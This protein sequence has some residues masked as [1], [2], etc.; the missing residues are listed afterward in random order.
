[1]KFGV[2]EDINDPLK[3]GRVR[4]RI[5]GIHTDDTSLVPIS[6]LPWAMCLCPIQ[7][8]SVS[9]I[10]ISPTGIVQGAWV[11]V[12]FLDNDNQ[13][14]VV[15][16]SIH[17]NPVKEVKDA[18]GEELIFSESSVDD[19]NV[20]RDSSGNPISTS[21]GTPVTTSPP[22]PPTETPTPIVEENSNDP[23]RVIPSKLGSVSA[24]HE[25]N[26][27]PGTVNAYSN[28]ADLGGASYGAYQFASYLKGPDTPTRDSVKK[29]QIINSPV[30]Q[31]L[32][33]SVYSDK[34]GG[35]SPATQAFDSMWR[36]LGSSNRVDFLADQHK[37][38][39][40]QYYQVCVDK[41]PPSI[42]NRKKAIHE[43]IWSMSVQ[44]GPGGAAS[45]IKSAVGNPEP[46]V[47]DS[48]VIE[49]L[50]D[51]RIQNVEVNFKSSP[52]LWPG[53]IRRFNEEKTQ[54]I[55]ITRTYENGVCQPVVLKEE[56]KVEFKE[57]TK[58]I[59]TEKKISVAPSANNPIRGFVDPNGEFPR[60][61]NEVD[62]SRLAR[63]IISDTAI[64]KKRRSLTTGKSAGK[65]T[66]SEPQTQYNTKYPFN[67][68]TETISG[69]VVELDDTPGYER[70]HVYHASGSFIEVHPNGTFVVKSKKDI[71]Q[72]S[73]YDTN[74]IIEGNQRTHVAQDSDTSVM[75]NL[76]IVV[77]GNTK[78]QVD[79]NAEVLVG[80]NAN[81]NVEGNF[82]TYVS[83]NASVT[84][85]GK[86]SV[87]ASRIDLN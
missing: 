3:A 30:N 9:G 66:I 36:S 40:R 59:V 57:D 24:K 32:K 22:T 19:Q 26:G 15:I 13:Y 78:I 82:D 17:G 48:K 4:V 72:I 16:G 53:L 41:L 6:S 73:A 51:Y 10:G 76:T 45:I 1:M 50:Y 18:V 60:R 35:L 84:C 11:A 31:Y 80:G 69:H 62:V 61:H 54:L 34:F 65:A 70:L 39:E 38:I 20:V 25:S 74:A 71:N 77:Q 86:Y 68:V 55:A 81:M 2:I 7:S 27:N 23:G 43:A 75:G 49:I 85:G 47:C 5:F 33:A 46:N 21:D 58:Q 28:G 14:P 8:G 83:K 29:A 12:E 52:K 37:Y 87:K 56:K 64:E 44:H 79:G 42:T 63:G 67:K